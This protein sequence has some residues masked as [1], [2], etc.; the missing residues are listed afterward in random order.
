MEDYKYF[1]VKVSFESF[2]ESTG[3]PKAIK[4][5][6][7]VDAMSPTEAEARTHTYLKG[8]VMDYKITDITQSKI[9]DVITGEGSI[10]TKVSESKVETT[11]VV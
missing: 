11:T 8:T 3:K 9:E 4:T 2:N 5:Q 1:L 7:L 6:Y 10:T